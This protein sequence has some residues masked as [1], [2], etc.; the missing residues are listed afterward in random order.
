MGFNSAALAAQAKANSNSAILAA[1]PRNAFGA[2]SRAS[3]RPVD[4]VLIGDSTQMIDG[5]GWWGAL[6]KAYGAR[7]GIWATALYPAQSSGN[8]YATGGYISALV[9]GT[10]GATS[11]A[12]SSFD[13]LGLPDANYL[14]TASGDMGGSNGVIV[15]NA[16]GFDITGNLKYHIWHG[17]FTT[18]S[19]AL[20]PGVRLEGSPYSVLATGSTVSTNT[21][22]FGEI[23]TTLSLAAGSRAATQLGFKTRVPG[24]TASVGPTLVLAQRVENL[25][26]E[27]GISVHSFYGVAGKSA[28]DMANWAKGNV[29][30]GTITGTINLSRLMW[31]FG[32]LRAMQIA[33]GHRPII[34]VRICTGLND[35][36]ITTGTAS[37]GW[38]ATTPG[39]GQNAYADNIDAIINRLETGWR[40]N[41][42]DLSELFFLIVPSCPSSEHLAQIAA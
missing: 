15:N 12:D 39:N 6:T 40:T 4:L 30:S 29:S 31:G 38:R 28:L 7:Y 1:Q 9:T 5:Y 18:G 35:R 19:G 14:Y 36:N 13:S 32:K 27:A 26:A 42:W 2:L 34:V 25:S 21:G 3:V 23:E 24:G 8:A 20:T 11:G 17:S 41:G 16:G 33:R 10:T 22:A 37:V